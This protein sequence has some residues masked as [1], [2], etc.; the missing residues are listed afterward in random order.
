MTGAWIIKKAWKVGV[1]GAA[2]WLLSWWFCQRLPYTTS[3]PEALLAE[4]LQTATSEPP[5]EVAVADKKY[6]IEP[7]FDYEIRGLVVATHDS[8]NWLDI[9]HSAWGDRINTKDICVL[10]GKNLTNGHLREMEFSHGDWT[11]YYSTHSQEAWQSF[12]QTKISN[13]HIIP[14]SAYVAHLVDTIEVGDEISLKGQL[15]NYSINGGP[16]RHSSTVRTDTGNGACEILYAQNVSI[17]RRHNGVWVKTAKISRGITMAALMAI[18]V[19]LFGLPFLR[20]N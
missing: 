4:P 18:V 6:L 3:Y 8:R 2:A 1:L 13:N 20:Q 12:D 11:C 16:H 10:W 17:L 7:L 19:S 14:A 9:S 5:H 15:V